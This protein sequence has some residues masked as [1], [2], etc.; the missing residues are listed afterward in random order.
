VAILII[1]YYFT[2]VFT[3]FKKKENYFNF[4]YLGFSLGNN[5]ASNVPLNLSF[6]STATTAATTASPFSL[7]NA[8]LN[9][10][11]TATLAGTQLTLGTTA[12]VT[13]SAAPG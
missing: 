7:G 8:A 12:N 10:K 13:T 5:A 6:G 1:I 3:I 9:V 2:C 4:N 11:P